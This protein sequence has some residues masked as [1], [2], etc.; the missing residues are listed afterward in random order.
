MFIFSQCV[1]NYKYRHFLC[2]AFALAKTKSHSLEELRGIKI[3][4]I[5][6]FSLFL[7]YTIYTYMNNK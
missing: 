1:N 6:D 4:N 5:N 2:F 7:L 3:N